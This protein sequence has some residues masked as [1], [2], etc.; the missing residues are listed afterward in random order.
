MHFVFSLLNVKQK[1]SDLGWRNYLFLLNYNFKYNC[2]YS[3]SSNCK[4]ITMK[5][6]SKHCDQFTNIRSLE[7]SSCQH[8]GFVLYFYTDLFKPHFS[9]SPSSSINLC[10]TSIFSIHNFVWNQLSSMLQNSYC[11]QQ[12]YGLAKLWYH[13]AIICAKENKF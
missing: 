12:H 3:R 7:F 9:L 6:F 8:C 13:T 4:S 2:N 5:R 10:L 11:F 1:S